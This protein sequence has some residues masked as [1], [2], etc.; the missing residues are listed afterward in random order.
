MADG[1][2]YIAMAWWITGLPGFAILFAVLGFNLVGDSLQS[3]IDP[4]LR[5]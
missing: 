4:R 3:Y 1:K 2:N 5:R